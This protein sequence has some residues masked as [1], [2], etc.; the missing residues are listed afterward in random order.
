MIAEVTR[1]FGG[2]H[3]QEPRT[4]YLYFYAE[5]GMNAHAEHS[6]KPHST[7]TYMSVFR[8]M[9][10]QELARMATKPAGSVGLNFAAQKKQ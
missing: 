5:H 7:E 1:V 3:Y 4:P 2:V 10:A 6:A 8:V 9:L